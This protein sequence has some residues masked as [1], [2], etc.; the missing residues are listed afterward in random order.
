MILLEP[1]E[2]DDDGLYSDYGWC[3]SGEK[4]CHAGQTSFF[5]FIDDEA[6]ETYKVQMPNVGE[7]DTAQKLEL[8]K[9]L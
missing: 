5:D 7:Y 8:K 2:T 1:Q 9:R 6:K 3:K 4:R